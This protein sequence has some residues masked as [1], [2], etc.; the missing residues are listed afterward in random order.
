MD[1]C[2][3][4]HTFHP[5]IP[6]GCFDLHTMQQFTSGSELNGIH[7]AH[8]LHPELLT[9]YCELQFKALRSDSKSLDISDSSF[10]HKIWVSFASSH[11]GKRPEVSW[12]HVYNLGLS[13]REQCFLSLFLSF[14]ERKHKVL[15]SHTWNSLRACQCCSCL[16]KL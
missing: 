15:P 2:D 10:S 3:A 16:K 8:I 5:W 4:L 1:G 6:P 14:C 9:V 12:P 11:V 7:Y 13:K